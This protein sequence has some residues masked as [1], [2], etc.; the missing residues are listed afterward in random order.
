[1]R[2][3]VLGGPHHGQHVDVDPTVTGEVHMLHPTEIHAILGPEGEVDFPRSHR[4][5]LAEY[6]IIRHGYRDMYTFC[7]Y[8]GPWTAS[9]IAAFLYQRLLDG[10][11]PARGLFPAGPEVDEVRRHEERATGYPQPERPHYTDDAV[12]IQS[13]HWL[14]VRAAEYADADG[15]SRDWAPEPGELRMARVMR[16]MEP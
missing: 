6:G 8:A 5:R 10:S 15:Y 11:R 9:C 7:V 2:A 1:M 12:A 3:R 4:Y 13:E 14:R 16:A